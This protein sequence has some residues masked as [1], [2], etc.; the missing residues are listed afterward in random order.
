[1]S[2]MVFEGP[3]EASA[4]SPEE[5]ANERQQVAEVDK[6]VGGMPPAQRQMMER[7]RSGQ[8]E[9]L[10]ETGRGRADGRHYTGRRDPPAKAHRAGVVSLRWR[11]Q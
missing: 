3:T 11:C 8:L 10:R 7:M 6:Q 5:R 2:T 9:R 1:M 4:M